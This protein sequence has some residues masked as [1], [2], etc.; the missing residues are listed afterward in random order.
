MTDHPK[1]KISADDDDEGP[2]EFRMTIHENRLI[3]GFEKPMRWIGLDRD[4]AIAFATTILR[5]AKELE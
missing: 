5:R 3:I 4:S 1:G 2:T